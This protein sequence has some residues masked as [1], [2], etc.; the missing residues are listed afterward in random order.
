M[1]TVNTSV[2]E[3]EATEDEARLHV[4]GLVAP[5]GLVTAQVIATAPLNPPDGDTVIVDVLS[6]VA[7]PASVILPL[8]LSRKELPLTE[9]IRTAVTE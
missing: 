1:A 7:P 5:V 4:A 2:P 8:L 9:G 3:P 6:E